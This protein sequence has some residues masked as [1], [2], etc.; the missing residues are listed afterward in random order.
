MPGKILVTGGA[1]YIGSHCVV[2]LI[3]AG[4]DC[5]IVDNFSN[6]YKESITRQETIIGKKIKYYEVDIRDREG[7][8]RVFEQHQFD[9]VIHFAG[10]KA[11]GVS[12]KQP[13][14][15]YHNNVTGS[16]TL[17]QCME[18]HNV[19]KIVFS[20]SSTVYGDPQYLPLDEKHPVGGC[21]NPYGTTKLMIE[22]ILEDAAK[23]RPSLNV[24]SLRYFN[25]VGAHESGLI[26][27]DPQDIPN[28]LMPYITQVAIGRRDVLNVYGN[29]Y[30]TR[31][32]TG[33]RD[34]IHVVD[35]VAGHVD[36]LQ[37]MDAL[38]CGFKAYNLGTGTGKSVL[39]VVASMEKAVGKKIPYKFAP[40][41]AGDIAENYADAKL[42]EEKLNWKTKK[43]MD[44]MCADSW[45]FQSKNPMG[46]K[47]SE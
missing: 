2:E 19:N 46:Y 22:L 23:A 28:N 45:N 21:S 12:C 37:K 35:L 25:P 44:D 47:S 7:L 1:G 34:Y 9:A 11:V 5:V 15:Y 30:E 3:K 39:E 4:F 27:E 14:E 38:G 40:R 41:R 18:K 8:N 36:A 20:S 26:G 6:A 33:V 10:L 31:D 32:G 43:N 29:D 42:A 17:L 24:V 16:I 13:L